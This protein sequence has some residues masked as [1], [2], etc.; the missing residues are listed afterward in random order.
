MPAF[1]DPHQE[2]S[3][4][5]PK[6]DQDK[7]DGEHR[8]SLESLGE[9]KIQSQR[10]GDDHAVQAARQTGGRVIS[11]DRSAEKHRL[12]Q[13]NLRRAGLAT[14]VDLMN[15]DATTIV[16][17]LPGPFDLVFFD[18]DR[19]TAPSQLEILRS[20]LTPNALV[21]A[22]NVTSHPEEIAPYLKAIV[23]MPEFDHMVVPIGKG[24]SLAYKAPNH[25]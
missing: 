5:A 15:G 18:A 20:K 1:P 12:A 8:Y 22:D 17:D 19:L 14:L 11:I 21:L 23:G 4:S 16:G 2:E 13:I 24:L 3:I 6:G 7:Q 10:Q 25:G 9:L